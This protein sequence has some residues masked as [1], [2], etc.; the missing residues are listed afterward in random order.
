MSI[1]THD[2]AGKLLAT[3]RNPEKGKLLANNTRLYQR[4]DNYAVRL[5]KTDVVTIQPDDTYILDTG[6]WDTVTTKERLNRFSP[7]WVRSHKGEW[8]LGDGSPFRDGVVVDHTGLPVEGTRQQATRPSDLL[9]TL[10]TIGLASS[11]YGILTEDDQESVERR[12]R[13]YR[14]HP[15]LDFP[16]DWDQLPVEEKKKRL[17]ALDQI[18]LDQPL[19]EAE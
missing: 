14:Q 1:L 16:V 13:F 17:D 7:A 3:A 11:I 12:A 4:G 10:K 9:N 15:L 5:H 2:S 19:A 18:A 6:G 8:Q